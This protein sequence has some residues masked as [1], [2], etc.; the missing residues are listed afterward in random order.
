MRIQALVRRVAA[1]GVD[2]VILAVS[3]D[4]DGDATAGLVRELLQPHAVRVTRLAFGLPADSGVGYADP[5]TL[6]RALGGR[7]P[8]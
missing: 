1:G 6:K 5:L 4:L 7:Q 8:A 2:E 3:T